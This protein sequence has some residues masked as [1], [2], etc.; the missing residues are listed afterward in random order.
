[1]ALAIVHHLHISNFLSFA[2]IAELFA[3]FNSKYLI[4]EFV[5]IKD[6]K[7][8]LLIKNKQRNFTGYTQENFTAAVLKY[9]KLMEIKKIEG[10]DRELL[11]L[12]KM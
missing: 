1:M 12:E 3:K 6:S 9:F 7:V 4:V 8:Q 11:L 2:Q 5:P 10:S